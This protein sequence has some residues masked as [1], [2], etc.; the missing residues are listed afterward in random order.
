MSGF[1]VLI[2]P[3]ILNSIYKGIIV[4]SQGIIMVESSTMN[5]KFFP[6]NSNLAKP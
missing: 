6:L 5:K 4:T 3:K 1:K 2:Q